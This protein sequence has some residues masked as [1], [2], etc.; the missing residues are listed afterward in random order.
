MPAPTAIPSCPL[1]IA[2][3]IREPRRRPGTSSVI[4]AWKELLRA[5]PAALSATK[6]TNTHTFP[7]GIRARAVTAAASRRELA[8]T[9]PLRPQRSDSTPPQG[10]ATTLASPPTANSR[11]RAEWLKPR[12]PSSQTGRYREYDAMPKN[13]RT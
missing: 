7:S 1:A 10:P 12:S 5:A 8:T 9:V 11:A 6:A 13:T 4:Q 2:R 3:L